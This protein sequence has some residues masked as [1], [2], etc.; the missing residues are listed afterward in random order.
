[1]HKPDVVHLHNFYHELSPGILP[2]LAAVRRKRSI[3]VIMTAHD[4]H[5]VCPNS[6]LCEVRGGDLE[7]VDLRKLDRIGALLTSR[8][9]HRGLAHS[10]LKLAQHLWAYHVR[11]WQRVIDLV[12]CPSRFLSEVLAAHGLPAVLLPNPVPAPPAVA[13]KPSGAL[14]LVFAGRVAA[15]KGLADFLGAFP[16]DLRAEMTIVGDGGE[17][18]RCRRLCHRRGLDDVV[19][20]LG[21][22][23]PTETLEIIGRSHALVL[24][25]RWYENA[26]LSL[27]EAIS[28]GT[29]I[30][31]SNLG[32]MKE[33]VETFGVGYM[34]DIHDHASIEA[35]LRSVE[36]DHATAR[37]N[38]FDVRAQLRLRSDDVY[39]DR[40]LSLYR[41]GSAERAA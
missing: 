38:A 31:V 34:F 28:L 7:A 22:R 21:R 24:P 30:V 14:R 33:I 25:S 41:G 2:T 12:I 27:I 9:D 35:A 23:T 3:R 18:E 1:M 29:N 20:F 6:G 16:V 11:R 5:L 19:T 13:A 32:G 37:L 39:I 4:G 36:A 26:P 15:G 40:L 8:W 10:S 17:L